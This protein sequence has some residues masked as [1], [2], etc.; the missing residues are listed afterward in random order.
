MKTVTKR[1]ILIPC[2]TEILQK[3]IAG[4]GPLSEELGVAIAD[5]WTQ[6]GVPALQYSLDKLSGGETE[7][8]WW[9]YF[10]IHKNDQ[11]LIGSGGY[12]GKP[13]D[14]MVEIGYEIAPDYRDKGL[15]TEMA[16]GLIQNAFAHPEVTKVIAHTLGQENASTKVLS[17]CGFKKTQEFEDPDDGLIWRWELYK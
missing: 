11:T 4:D 15:A 16:K 17:K 7:Q 8:D 10:P 12:K 13:V 5:Q 9:T 6:F 14:G 3:A 1:L 2:G